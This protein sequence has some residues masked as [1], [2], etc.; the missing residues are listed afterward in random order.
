MKNKIFLLK[1]LSK[2]ILKEKKKSK[3]LVHCHG[4][5]D[6]L[7]IG[8]IKH[9][10]KAKEQGDKLIVT[11]T[12]DKY[13]NKG[14]GRPVFNENLRCQA[15]AA[16]DVVDYVAINDSPTA[17][18]PIK[19]LR[20]NIYCKGTDYKNFVDDIT[21]EIKNELK[22]VKKIKGKIFFTEEV[23]FSSSRLINRSTDFFSQKQKRIFKKINVKLNFKEIKDI[24]NDFNKF[25]VL[26]I[27]ETIIDQYNFCEAL[28]KS[29]KEP[30]LVLK[31]MQ[32]DQYLGGVLGIARNI[33]EICKNITVISMLGEKKEY[34]KDINK[35]LP[36][37][38]LKKFIFK[39]DSPT[40]VKKRYVDNLSQSKIIGVYNINDE[41][42][43]K[44]DEAKFNKFLK[45][46]ITKYDLVIVS[47]YGHGLISKKSANMICKN[48]KFMALNAQ[49][50]A[51]NIGYHT[52]RNYNNF[53]TL[54]INEK[55]IRH[56]MRD[57]VSKLEFLMSNLSKEK[58]IEN[59]I[60]TV[61]NRGS[62]LYAKKQNKFFYADAFAYK[63]VD[64]VGAGDTMLSVI[65]LCL[66]SKIDYNLTLLISSLAA[67]QSVESIGNKNT[68]KKLK[69]LKTL[70]SILK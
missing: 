4:V 11:I 67:A 7:H 55:E 17:V 62:I 50:N 30:I 10:E 24:I 33:S 25:K 9:L 18:N 22:E 65:G 56:E 13:V 26:I 63:I 31:E 38:I 43:N 23:T 60:V 69:I 37:N 15:I 39:K 27:G 12:S 3:I 70:E 41:I 35:N 2:I 45:S 34:L 40:I 28:G 64:K 8:H 53:N 47:D 29:G 36:K 1:D 46:E 6:L 68:I 16:L 58:K 20:P 51:S 32:K 57:K 49:V 52:I 5:F 44:K 59:V 42:L 14:P 48:S 66:K 19:I 61:G 54:I 21:G